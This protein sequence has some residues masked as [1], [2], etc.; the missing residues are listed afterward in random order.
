MIK[1]IKSCKCFENIPKE[2]ILMFQTFESDVQKLW[3]L[4]EEQGVKMVES[5]WEDILHV[6]NRELRDIIRDMIDKTN[7]AII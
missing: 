4:K 1:E 3:K 7:E 2:E 6:N 5:A